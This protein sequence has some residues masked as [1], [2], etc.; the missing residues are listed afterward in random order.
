[1]ATAL[2]IIED[3]AANKISVE[4]QF[5]RFVDSGAKQGIMKKVKTTNP[6]VDEEIVDLV[7]NPPTPIPNPDHT[8]RYPTTNHHQ[9]YRHL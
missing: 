3:A 7:S 9:F 6:P 5:K 4:T 1:M 2:N 8:R